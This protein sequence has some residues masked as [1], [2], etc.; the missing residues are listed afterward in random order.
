MALVD[1]YGAPSLFITITCNPLWSEISAEL[2]PGKTA[3]DCPDLVARVFRMKLDTINE[4]LKTMFVTVLGFVQTIEFQ[5]RG[6]PHAHTLI[7]L[8]PQDK[9][10]GA[11]IINLCAA[12]AIQ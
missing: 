7:I 6:L 2:P 1:R 4:D 10:T 5:K 11:E 8:A 12:L 3:A 9:R